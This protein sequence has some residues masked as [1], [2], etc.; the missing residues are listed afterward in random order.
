MPYDRLREDAKSCPPFPLNVCQ[1]SWTDFAC[2]L[3]WIVWHRSAIGAI[4][5]VVTPSVARMTMVMEVVQIFVWSIRIIAAPRHPAG[6]PL[7]G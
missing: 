5:G 2:L 1:Y 7:K 6:D 3:I 4:A